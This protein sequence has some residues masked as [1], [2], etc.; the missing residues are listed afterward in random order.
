MAKTNAIALAAIASIN[1]H[2]REVAESTL[3]GI[4]TLTDCNGNVYTLR[5]W[6]RSDSS[7]KYLLECRNT[8]QAI[9]NM[10]RA[11]LPTNAVDFDDPADMFAAI[12]AT[13]NV[14][15]SISFEIKES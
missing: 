8:P 3:A 15:K 14:A 1:K 11:D 13:K 4:V 9:G 12:V 7:L 2:N 5:V 10:F 6:V